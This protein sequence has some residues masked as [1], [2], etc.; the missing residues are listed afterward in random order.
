MLP[1]LVLK[2]IRTLVVSAAML[3]TLVC[4]HAVVDAAPA[5][6]PSARQRVEFG[7]DSFPWIR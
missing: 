6:D 2:N 1:S 3:M 4:V 5:Q 7:V